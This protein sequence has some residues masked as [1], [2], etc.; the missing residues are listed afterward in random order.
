MGG[1]EGPNMG[2]TC[3]YPREGIDA[4]DLPV[5]YFTLIV[6]LLSSFGIFDHGGTSS[7]SAFSITGEYVFIIACESASDFPSNAFWRSDTG[8][9]PINVDAGYSAYALAMP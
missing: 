5:N 9:M 1:K 8:T 7:P 2:I 4:D 3:V 6:I